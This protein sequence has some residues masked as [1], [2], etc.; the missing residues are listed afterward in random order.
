MASVV[1]CALRDSAN[2]VA[3][4]ILMAGIVHH[5][6]QI[7]EAVAQLAFH[8][9]KSEQ[10][11]RSRRNP[12]RRQTGG[13]RRC[14]LH[15]L[16]GNRNFLNQSIGRLGYCEEQQ[17]ANSRHFISSSRRAFAAAALD[18]FCSSNRSITSRALARFP[19]VTYVFPRF[20]YKSSS[21]GAMRM[22]YSNA[23]MASFGCPICTYNTPR[24]LIAPVLP[25]CSAIA[26]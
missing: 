17:Q 5:Q 15:H 19:S 12:R 4:R 23:A 1:V 14:D 22:P 18:G 21:R 13:W 3:K 16:P 2:Q 8:H 20:M 10:R 11:R 9:S 6:V 26:F 25:G 24:L 7:A